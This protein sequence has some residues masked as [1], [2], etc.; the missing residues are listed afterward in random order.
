MSSTTHP[1]EKNDRLLSVSIGTRETFHERAKTRSG[2]VQDTFRTRSGHVQDTFTASPRR[3][4]DISQTVLKVF[5]P[6][7]DERKSSRNQKSNPRKTFSGWRQTSAGLIRAPKKS[8]WPLSGDRP[9]SMI[10][11]RLSRH[12][13][14]TSSA[15]R[16]RI[17][18]TSSAHR[19]RIVGTSSYG[20][21]DVNRTSTTDPMNLSTKVFP[22]EHY[23]VCGTVS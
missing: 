1:I 21:R 23:E 10:R 4:G 15:H 17:V 11:L 2:H 19:R 5:R 3:V 22:T 20:P 16:R 13:V 18:G 8:F 9:R 6:I 14:G 7:S 12:I